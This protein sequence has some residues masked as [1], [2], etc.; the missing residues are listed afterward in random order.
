MVLQRMANILRN[1]GLNRVSH[2]GLPLDP[3]CHPSQVHTPD[4]TRAAADA[5]RLENAALDQQGPPKKT[6]QCEAGAAG[7]LRDTH[8]RRR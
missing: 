6:L 1:E 4:P 2:E 5:H 7:R 8:W 3:A